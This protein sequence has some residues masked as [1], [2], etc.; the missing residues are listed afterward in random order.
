MHP[1]A[2][3]DQWD[4]PLSEEGLQ[5]AELLAR[6]LSLLDPQPAAVYAS[7]L[8]RASETALAF[9]DAAGLEVTLDE[10]LMEAHIGDWEAK[11]FEEILAS[12]DELLHRVREQ[13]EIWSRAP[14]GERERDFRARVVGALERALEEHPDGDVLVFCHGGVI[15][16]YMG[17]VL[18][19]PQGMFFLP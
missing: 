19:L 9:S 2:R 6:R 18:G 7:P 11:P 15:N 12:D 16:A 13:R 3:G 14:S 4:P 10:D 5:Q 8:R 17:E 1:T